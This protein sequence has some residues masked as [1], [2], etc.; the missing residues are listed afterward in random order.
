MILLLKLHIGIV[1]ISGTL[2][3]LPRD[4]KLISLQI[5]IYQEFIIVTIVSPFEQSLINKNIYI[6]IY[7]EVIVSVPVGRFFKNTHTFE[8]VAVEWETISSSM[9]HFFFYSEKITGT[10]TKFLPRH[11]MGKCEMLKNIKTTW[12][13]RTR[14]DVNDRDLLYIDTNARTVNKVGRGME[15]ISHQL[16]ILQ[17]YHCKNG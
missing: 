9:T 6:Y 7:S 8:S 12:M 11:R 4:S 3:Q 1:D 17:R 10:N 5:Y 16:H 2:L 13:R 15:A 14:D